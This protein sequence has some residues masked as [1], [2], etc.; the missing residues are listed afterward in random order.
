MA[1]VL[2]R[3]SFAS[4]LLPLGIALQSGRLQAQL[5]HPRPSW[6]ATGPREGTRVDANSD[7]LAREHLP[8]VSLPARPRLQRPFDLV[9]RIGDPNHPQRSDHFIAWVEAAYADELLFVADLSPSVPFP[10]VRIP[11]ILRR[12][13]LLTIRA[14]CTRHGTFLWQQAL[15]PT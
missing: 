7:G 9:V 3:R 12:P 1:E 14:H 5:L 15:T 2:S 8:F 13:G 6:S 10:V 4:A 11:V